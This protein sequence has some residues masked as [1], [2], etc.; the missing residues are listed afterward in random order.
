[1]AITQSVPQELWE[2]VEALKGIYTNPSSQGWSSEQ[3][4]FIA[5]TFGVS[6]NFRPYD[7][8]PVAYFLQPVFSPLRNRFPRLHLQGA[9]MQFKSVNMKAA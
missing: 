3:L 7:L 5:K 1:M 6:S 2:T 4:D 8:S 9:N